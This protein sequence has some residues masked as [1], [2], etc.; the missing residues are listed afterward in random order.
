MTSYRNELI[1][2]NS[3]SKLAKVQ[4]YKNYGVAIMIICDM[5]EKIK[6][7]YYGIYLGDKIFLANKNGKV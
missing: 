6:D 5:K 4:I 7:I 1:I 3:I 2:N